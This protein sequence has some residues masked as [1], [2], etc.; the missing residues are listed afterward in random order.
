MFGILN[1]FPNIKKICCC[2]Y[3][4]TSSIKNR[5]ARIYTYISIQLETPR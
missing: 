2:Y 5:F 4:D 3:K 1:S